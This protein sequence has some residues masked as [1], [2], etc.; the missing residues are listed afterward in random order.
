MHKVHV[1]GLISVPQAVVHASE[2]GI[3]RHEGA[4]HDRGQEDEGHG[5]ADDCVQDA[6]DLA[7]ARERRLVAVADG[8]DH[9]AGEEE[10][11]AKAPRGDAGTV[12]E[13]GH[14]AVVGLHHVE[15]E[16]LE[17][18]VLHVV[19]FEEGLLPGYQLLR[20]GRLDWA[21]DGGEHRCP[22][23]QVEKE[24]HAYTS[25]TE[26]VYREKLLKC[27]SN[28]TSLTQTQEPPVRPPIVRVATGVAPLF[29]NLGQHLVS[30]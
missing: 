19:L 10:R 8:G 11:L 28:M 3:D 27:P 22:E 2:Q 29:V 6:E 25:L 21:L 1:D 26:Y 7:L 20:F 12:S 4:L 5:D 15:H 24:E 17:V 13:D 9:G 18:V 30:G 23:S 16:L 14:P